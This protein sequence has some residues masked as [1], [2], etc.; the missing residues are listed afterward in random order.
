MATVSRCPTCAAEVNDQIV[1]YRCGTLLAVEASLQRTKGRLAA[2]VADKRNALLP[3][4]LGAHHFLWAC[5]VIPFFLLPPLV[6]LI[7]A[8]GAMRRGA[9]QRISADFEWIAVISAI[10]LV[11]SSL[12]LYKYYF[13]LNDL[14]LQGPEMLRAFV[15]R[16]FFFMQPQQPTMPKPIPV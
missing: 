2:F 13:V 8:V 15:R 7:Y 3:R 4:R 16:W 10:N 5:A 6:S 12:V 9:A 14:L 11:V 1:C